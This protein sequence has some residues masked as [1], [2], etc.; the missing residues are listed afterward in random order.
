MQ[1]PPRTNKDLLT[2][3]EQHV[4]RGP[5]NVTPLFAARAQ[6]AKVWDVEGKEYMD[7]A[8]GIGVVNAGHCPPSVVEAIRDQAGKFLHTCFHVMMYEPYVA[9][10]KRL[11]ALAPGAFPKKTMFANS[12]AEAV[13]N[14]VKVARAHTKR[15]AVICF[16]DAFHGRTLLALSLTSKVDP[17]KLGFAPFA[18]EVYRMPYAYCYRCPIGLKYPSCNVACA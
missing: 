2:E 17:Y 15:P 1:K 3:R 11:N 16:E 8:G 13:E 14:G 10:A 5:F 9:L 7:F 18:P 12:G 6:G 4:P